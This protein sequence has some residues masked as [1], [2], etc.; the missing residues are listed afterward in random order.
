MR[1]SSNLRL[2]TFF[3]AAVVALALV[4]AVTVFNAAA[5]VDAVH[6]IEVLAKAD[7]HADVSSTIDSGQR[8][9]VPALRIGEQIAAVRGWAAASYSTASYGVVLMALRLRLVTCVSILLAV[10]RVRVAVVA[11]WKFLRRRRR[12][13]G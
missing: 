7:V 1:L 10:L 12:S 9:S 13:C 11:V 3:F 8:G 4:A 2:T 5:Y 6:H